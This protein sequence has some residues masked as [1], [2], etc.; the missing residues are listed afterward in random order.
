MTLKVLVF[1]AGVLCAAFVVVALHWPTQTMLVVAMSVVLALLLRASRR[2][3]LGNVSPARSVVAITLLPIAVA[4]SG[5]SAVISAVALIAI[6]LLI[7]ISRRDGVFR[8]HWSF[9]LLLA[10][11][12]IVWAQLEDLTS[13]AKVSLVTLILVLVASRF[14]PS[15]LAV[16]IVNGIG[17]YLA[18]NVLGWAVG[19]RSPSAAERVGGYEGGLL[20]AERVL[21]PFTPS[22]NTIAAVAAVY[23]L[24]CVGIAMSSRLHWHQ[25][26][27]LFL[28]GF[29]LLAAGARAP[30]AIAVAGG[31]IIVLAP[32]VVARLSPL[33]V[34][35]AL[36][37]PLFFFMIGTW[38]QVVSI[39]LTS[40]LP[41]LSS[42]SG[43]GGNESLNGREFIWSEAFLHWQALEPLRQTFGYGP[44]GHFKSGASMT[45]SRLFDQFTTDVSSISPHSSLL[46]QLFDGGILGAACLFIALVGG[47]ITA[48]RRYLGGI[49]QHGLLAVVTL[50]GLSLA[51]SLES[52][53]APSTIGE[54]F[55]IAAGALCLLSEEK[56]SRTIV[57]M[58]RDALTQI[59][60]GVVS[61]APAVENTGK[62]RAGLG[63]PA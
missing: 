51:A 47:A 3:R 44:G 39:W 30:I 37:L 8:P 11:G 34:A 42:R 25:S 27:A 6:V 15:R 21:F 41:F 59:P 16:S 28:A 63:R 40:A 45:Y 38:V 57:L 49:G 1:G 53:L 23:V 4:L 50:A 60:V 35:A 43:Q 61:T 36:T 2:A 52:A 17:L 31:A 20:F 14:E 58:R 18:V 62:T 24:A 12:A 13:I 48:G 32:R 9:Y 46:Q 33:V 26:G 22:V 55:L 7:L 19:L 5:H 56:S 29:I 10:S 54:L